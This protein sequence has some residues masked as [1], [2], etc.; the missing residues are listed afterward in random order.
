MLLLPP[1]EPNQTAPDRRTA[2]SNAAASPP[3]IGLP[4]STRA[5]RLDT[6]MSTT[7]PDDYSQRTS[8]SRRCAGQRQLV[9]IVPEGVVHGSADALHHADGAGREDSS[10]RDSVFMA[11]WRGIKDVCV[12]RCVRGGAELATL[13]PAA[14]PRPPPALHANC[15]P[16]PTTPPSFFPPRAKATTWSACCPAASIGS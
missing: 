7:E 15:P 9:A 14:Q 4:G 6:T 5:T 1:L 11:G 13:R 12:R 8:R 10:N 16:T 3:V 2:G